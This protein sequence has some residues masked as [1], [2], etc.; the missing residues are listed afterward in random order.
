MA[1]IKL[2]ELTAC[3]I[4]FTPVILG[5]IAHPHSIMSTQIIQEYEFAHY[6]QYPIPMFDQII[7]FFQ[8][9]CS[10]KTS[11]VV[12]QV[13]IN[14]FT[15]KQSHCYF[16]FHVY[17]LILYPDYIPNHS[18]FKITFILF[19]K[20]QVVDINLIAFDKCDSTG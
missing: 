20:G 12:V 3:Y 5:K 18:N 13:F 1:D 19:R 2:Y 9:V 8:S 15:F 4:W 17:T 16:I 6:R 10:Y 11:G 14:A 7:S